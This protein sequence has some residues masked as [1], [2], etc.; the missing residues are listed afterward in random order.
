MKVWSARQCTKHQLGKG[1]LAKLANLGQTALLSLCLEIWIAKMR[2]TSDHQRELQPDLPIWTRLLSL[3]IN[4]QPGSDQQHISPPRHQ[5]IHLATWTNAFCNLGKYIF[6]S[7][8]YIL[9]LGRDFFLANR[10]QPGR[11]QHTILCQDWKYIWLFGQIH[12]T[13]TTNTL[14]NLDKSI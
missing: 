8:K 11:D 2:N 9:P 5:K 14:K 4:G 3:T 6:N 7:D 12:F 13:F 10:S 1:A